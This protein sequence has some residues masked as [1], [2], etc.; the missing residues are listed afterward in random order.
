MA[1]L[2]KQSTGQFKKDYK[3]GLEFLNAKQ[4]RQMTARKGEVG[5]SGSLANCGADQ[6]HGT[7][8]QVPVRQPLIDV[9]PLVTDILTASRRPEKAL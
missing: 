8:V 3:E 6:I 5:C 9:D 1:T 7:A 2:D 4:K